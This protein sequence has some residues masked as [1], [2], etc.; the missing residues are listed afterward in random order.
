LILFDLFSNI[1]MFYKKQAL[2]RRK[3]NE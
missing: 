3:R 2:L 1:A